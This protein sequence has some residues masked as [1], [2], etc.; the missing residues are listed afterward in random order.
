VPDGTGRAAIRAFQNPFHKPTFLGDRQEAV[1]KIIS[2]L[3][4]EHPKFRAKSEAGVFWCLNESNRLPE[5]KCQGWGEPD[6]DIGDG[7]CGFV[8]G[9]LR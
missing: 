3:L 9:S 5:N 8:S 2:D 7:D 1:S 4:C 6:H